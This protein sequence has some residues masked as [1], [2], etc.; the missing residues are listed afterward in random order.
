KAGQDVSEFELR[1]ARSANIPIVNEYVTRQRER[2]YEAMGAPREFAS[3]EGFQQ[4]EEDRLKNERRTVGEDL[5]ERANRQIETPQRFSPNAEADQQDRVNKWQQEFSQKVEARAKV[6]VN[7]SYKIELQPSPEMEQQ[8][9]QAW[10]IAVKSYFENDNQRVQ[11]LLE[12]LM[13]QRDQQTARIISRIN[14][15]GRLLA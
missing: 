3:Q 5:F 9:A 15:Q 1:M 10:N 13:K 8:I 12:E 2:N 11:S 6:A 7:S 14:Q 4:L